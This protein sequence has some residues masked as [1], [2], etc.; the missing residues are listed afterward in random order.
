[1]ATVDD[2]EPD[3]L[4]R[5]FDAQAFNPCVGHTLVSADDRTRVWYIRLAP[6]D[7]IGFHRHV[8][9]YFW[10]A[11]T[12][13]RAVSR[14]DGGAPAEKA[15]VAGETRH[16]RFAAGEYMVHDLENVGD[17]DLIFITVEHLASANAPL[18]LPPG[19]SPTNAIGDILRS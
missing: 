16:M 4:A 18:P 2:L 9:D 8:L 17:R 1:M 15:Y 14:R 7:R 3:A 13:G 12:D 6:G 5:E 11:L 10:T 19:V